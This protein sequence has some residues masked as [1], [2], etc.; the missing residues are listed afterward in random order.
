MDKI[1]AERGS[2]FDTILSHLFKCMDEGLE[3]DLSRIVDSGKEKLILAAIEKVGG[4]LLRPIKDE[5]PKDIEY[6][7]IKT[8]LKK[9]GN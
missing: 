2:K 6:Y 4:T 9:L 7:E 8:V 5:L 3:V 1:A